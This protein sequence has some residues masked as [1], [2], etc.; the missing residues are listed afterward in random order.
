[1]E[2][3]HCRQVNL[4]FHQSASELASGSPY[5]ERITEFYELDYI[6]SSESGSIRTEGEESSL[7]RGMLFLRV[8]GMRVQGFARY[9]SW[10]L[11]FDAKEQLS[12][13]R[14][15]YHL[16]S[17]LCT[18]IFQTLYDLHIQRPADCEYLMDY[19]I[20][21]LLFHLYQEEFHIRKRSTSSSLE[22]VREMMES[23]WR[24]NLPLDYYVTLSGYSKSRFCHLFQELYQISP[25]HFLHK[26]RLQ[27]LCYKLI[28]TEAPV[29][30][31]MIEH[32]FANEQSFFRAFR[33]FTGE[34]PLG[35]R[36]KHR[37]SQSG[38]HRSSMSAEK[39][40]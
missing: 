31:L 39:P 12:F 24:Q 23:S 34:T 22:F 13:P 6:L 26:L 17:E 28:E 18:P 32:G 1:M 9:S 35:Y 3:I 30:E 8:P 20:N 7:S 5:P 15:F 33:K 4:L 38:K 19:Y 37:L 16:P 21:Q 25:I 10:Y 14:L 36:R 2:L 27:S 29:K 11:T 40:Q